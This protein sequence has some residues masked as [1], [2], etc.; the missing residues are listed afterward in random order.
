MKKF[1]NMRLLRLTSLCLISLISICFSG[2]AQETISTTAAPLNTKA[3]PTTVS[4]IPTTIKTSPSQTTTASSVSLT[5]YSISSVVQK[6]GPSVVM[7]VTEGIDWSYYVSPIPESGAGSGIIISSDGYI[8]TNN[9]VIE[10]ATVIK[11]YLSDGRAF[12][13]AVQGTD[14]FSDLAVIKINANNLPAAVFGN[15]TNLGIGQ[16]VVAIGNA[17]ALSG[18]YT[19][20]SGIVSALGRSIQ[21][22]NKPVIHDLLQTDA[23][24]NPGNS[25]GPLVTLDG[26]VIG[27]NT[28]I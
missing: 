8:A 12:D 11:V 24:I 9:H 26:K 27:I 22:S 17:F 2:C 23:A 3:A 5:S 14:P 15:S 7:I 6:I 19:V 13:A 16:P 28:A 18:G 1:F 21:L 25:G 10:N 4:T 20:T